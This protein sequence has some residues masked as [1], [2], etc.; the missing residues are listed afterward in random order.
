MP[1]ATEIR[2]L[3]L[4]D[5]RAQTVNARYMRKE[6]FDQLTRN[7]ARDG[8]L[9]SVPLVYQ[10]PGETPEILSGHHRIAAALPRSA[11]TSR[12]TS[13]SCSMSS[14]SRKSSPGS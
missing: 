7:I 13:W 9:T 11:P 10:P 14:R 12:P 4:A 8:V 5:L 1:L 3:R 2:R 6:Q